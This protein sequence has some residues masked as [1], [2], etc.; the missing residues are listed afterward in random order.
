METLEHLL[1]FCPHYREARETLTRLWTSTL[2]P[3]ILVLVLSILTGP[4]S[5]LIQFILDPSFHPVFRDL[6]D[7]LG[8]APLFTIF[9]LTRSWCYSLHKERA[10]LLGRFQFD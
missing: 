4:P 5:E 1:V 10:K 6:T 3:A 7:K 2:D 8:P 9:Y